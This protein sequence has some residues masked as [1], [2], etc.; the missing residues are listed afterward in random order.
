MKIEYMNP[1][2]WYYTGVS[3][4]PTLK[5]GEILDIEPYDGTKIR[6]GDV[7]VFSVSGKDKFVIHRVVSVHGSGIRTRGD[8]NQEIDPWMISSDDI[9]GKVTYARSSRRRRS[10]IGGP[11]G[12]MLA[13]SVRVL[14]KSTLLLKAV[15]RPLYHRLAAEG[16]VRKLI[17]LEKRLRVVAVKRKGVIEQ[18]LLWGRYVIG[19]F[20]PHAGQWQIRH[21]FRLF[22]DE[23]ALPGQRPV[24]AFVP[25][26]MMQ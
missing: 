15:L 17:S 8:N 21:P 2:E 7:I 10:I 4:D 19:I 3:M 9:V 13:G 26:N 1:Q 18:K 20:T 12:H 5:A 24:N 25:K 11:A 22:V 6:R 14:R 16:T 23:N